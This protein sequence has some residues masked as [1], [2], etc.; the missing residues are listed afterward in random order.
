[1]LARTAIVLVVVALLAA[2]CGV[3]SS[4]PYTAKGSVACFRA[5]GFTGV[6]TNPAKV[7]FIAG[8]APNGG[9]A[10][11]SP[12]GNALTI[13]FAGDEKGA[14]STAAVYR[15]KAPPALRRH[16]A[17]IL[18]TQRNAVLVWTTSP[19]ADELSRALACLAP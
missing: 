16:M 5:K 15:R 4:K 11:R 2:G 14:A 13:A 12:A 18:E 9:L 10:G 1:M 17:D 8:F 6:S 7:G 3:R 19:T